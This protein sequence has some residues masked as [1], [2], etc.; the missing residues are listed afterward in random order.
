MPAIAGTGNLPPART[1][2]GAW[3]SR[4]K[5]VP[6]FPGRIGQNRPTLRPLEAVSY[7]RR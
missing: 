7:R 3:L 4:V 6:E 1:G 2:L 5:E